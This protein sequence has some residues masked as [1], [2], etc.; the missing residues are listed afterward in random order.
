MEYLLKENIVFKSL[1]KNQLTKK[2]KEVI[3]P[4]AL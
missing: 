3:V 4:S 2:G 1:I